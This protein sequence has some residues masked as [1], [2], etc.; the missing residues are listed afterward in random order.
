MNSKDILFEQPKDRGYFLAGSDT[1]F[2]MKGV[3]VEKKEWQMKRNFSVT[4]QGRGGSDSGSRRRL[5]AGPGLPKL[6]KTSRK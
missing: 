5:A 1:V 3:P 6:I 4:G 2:K